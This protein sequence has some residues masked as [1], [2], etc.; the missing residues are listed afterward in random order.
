M[1]PPNHNTPFIYSEYCNRKDGLRFEVIDGE[2]INMTPSPTPKHQDILGGLYSEFRSYL[3]GKACKVF[4]SPIDVCLFSS[5][6]TDESDIQDW[7]QPDLLIICDSNK[8]REKRIT[9]APDFIIEVLSPSTTKVDRVL[10]Y[11]AYAKAGVKEYWIVDPYHE[12]VE[13][14]ILHNKTF[15]HSGQYFRTDHV[16]ISLFSDFMLDLNHIFM[17]ES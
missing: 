5:N 15:E 10:K 14:F 4:I 8:I 6:D 1:T 11:N 3:K 2:I 13:S 16:P 17:T 7:L 12:F 9:G